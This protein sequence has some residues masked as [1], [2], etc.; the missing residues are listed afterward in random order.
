MGSAAA[1]RIGATLRRPNPGS[2]S[3]TCFDASRL[4]TSPD[5]RVRTDDADMSVWKLGDWVDQP[6][7]R[8]PQEHD[9]IAWFAFDTAVSL[10]LAHPTYPD[11]L[12]S[13]LSTR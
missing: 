8:D 5:A 12:R 4:A 1:D 10:P 13:L 2:A 7:N 6:N 9:T 3:G 11:L